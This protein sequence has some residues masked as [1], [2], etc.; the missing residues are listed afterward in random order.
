VVV[1]DEHKSLGDHQHKDQ[2][3]DS[4]CREKIGHFIFRC[5]GDSRR[6]GRLL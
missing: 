5:F 3:N 4:A 6:R 2:V 1:P